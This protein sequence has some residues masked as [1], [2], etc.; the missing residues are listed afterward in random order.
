MRFPKSVFGSVLVFAAFPLWSAGASAQAADPAANPPAAAALP[1]SE[2]ASAFEARLAKELG[3]SGGL[4]AE[5]LAASAVSTS[6]SLQAKRTELASKSAETDKARWGYLPRVTLGARYTRLSSIATPQLGSLVA[7][8]T[9]PDGPLR[10]D[11]PLVKVPFSFP[12]VL[13]QYSLT[14]ALLVPVSDYFFRVAPAS[15]ASSAN[16]RAA[17]HEV[18]ATARAVAT[19]AKGLYYAWVGARLSSIVAELSLDLA[20]AHGEDVKHALEAGTASPA[21]KLRVDSLIA[22]AERALESARHAAVDLE[23][24]IRIARH[25]SESATYAVGEDVRGEVAPGGLPDDLRVLVRHALEHRPELRALAAR[26]DAAARAVSLERAAYLPRLDLFAD[27]AYANPNQRYFPQQ[28]EWKGTWDAGAQLTWVVTD[29]PAAAASTRAA[30]ANLASLRS[31]VR[32]L[33]D[34]IRREV[35]QALQARLDAR[36]GVRTSKTGLEAAEESY[37]VRRA[38]FQNGRAT[39]TELLD[40]EL[41]LTRA[42]LAALNA[43]LELRM[44]AARLSYAVGEGKPQS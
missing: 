27:A 29:V 7:A 38:L 12:Q 17:R 33:Q 1:R 23:E 20:R 15:S 21:D 31:E 41:E 14:A 30:E 35:S 34:R 16:E 43:G 10:A 36:S 22:D 18:D 8:P 32:A 37:R 28:K 6:F 3:V 5:A 24:Q 13:D 2:A 39:S 40:A 4:T 25:D 44:S 19:D 42:R 9:E 11:A 26:S